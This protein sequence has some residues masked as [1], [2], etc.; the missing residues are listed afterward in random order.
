M[1]EYNFKAA[2]EFGW[3]LV[4]A[5]GLAAVQLLSS[6]DADKLQDPLFWKITIGGAVI[7]AVTGAVID[8]SKNHQPSPRLTQDDIDG[9]VAKAVAEQLAKQQAPQILTP[10]G[11]SH[12]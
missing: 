7:R 3:A 5:A 11:G 2:Q 4:T 6:A 8:W 9:M 12:G 10:T 1:P